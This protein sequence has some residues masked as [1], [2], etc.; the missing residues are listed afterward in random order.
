MSQKFTYEQTKEI[1]EAVGLELLETESKGVDYKY[2]CKDSEGYFYKRSTHTC[3]HTLKM[4]KRYQ[5]DIDYT[6]STRNPYFY[7][8]MLLYME[9]RDNQGTKLL[10][11]KEDIRNVDM[12]LTFKCGLCGR[13]FTQTWHTFVKKKDK[14]C[15]MCFNQKRAKGET[16]TKH[17]DSNKYHE[18]ARKNGVVILDGPQIKYKDKVTVQDKEGYRGLTSS[19][20]IMR[21][22]GFERFGYRNPYALD[23]LRLFAFKKN[24]D[25]VIY[26][27]EYKGHNY[28]F[29]VMCGCGNDFEVDAVHFT[30]GKYQCNECRVKQSAIAAKVELWLNA[31]TI[32]YQKEK[33]FEQCVYKKTLPFDF[34]LPQYNSCIEVDGLGHYRPVNF[35][36]NKERAKKTYEQRQIIDEI[37]T[38][39]CEDNNIPLLRLPFWEIEDDKTYKTRLEQ[40]LSIK[41]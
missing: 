3:Q 5:S 17:I 21:E 41:D 30:E 4:K 16:N 31:H 36:G 10:T 35:C 24:W 32:E 19:A 15:N 12:R 39:Y 20:V 18:Q 34:Y 29:K 23:N 25:C 22:E 7:K 38:K 14:C 40:F 13:E 33:R 37:K 9:K 6:F 2:D 27:Q 28:K 8:N 26:N 11:P 1:F